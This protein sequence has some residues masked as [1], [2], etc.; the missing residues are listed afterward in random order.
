MVTVRSATLD[1]K[2]FALSS[3][4]VPYLRFPRGSDKL[5]L[6]VCL[7]IHARADLLMDCR[8]L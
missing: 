3:H 1:T 6:F 8:Q 7:L 5:L 2:H 4:S